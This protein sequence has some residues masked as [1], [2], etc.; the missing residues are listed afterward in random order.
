VLLLNS[1][2]CGDV[3]AV[4]LCMKIG[5]TQVV[6]GTD[7]DVQSRATG[8]QS[9]RKAPKGRS[10]ALF[11]GPQSAALL[12]DFSGRVSEWTPRR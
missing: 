1:A 3:L 4:G 5:G 6:G 12:P 11:C 10:L 9:L 8:L 7:K 2:M